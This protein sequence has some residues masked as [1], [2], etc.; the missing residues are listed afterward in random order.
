MGRVYGGGRF[1]ESGLG[2]TRQARA[3]IP[4]TTGG[5]PAAV[6]GHGVN[7]S[8]RSILSPIQHGLFWFNGFLPLDPFVVWSPARLT[9]TGCP[10]QFRASDF[11]KAVITLGKPEGFER[12]ASWI[13]PSSSARSRL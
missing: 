3:L 2:A 5:G 11:R 6:S 13:T 10:F 1:Y 12:G 4:M 8:L 9:A 7:P